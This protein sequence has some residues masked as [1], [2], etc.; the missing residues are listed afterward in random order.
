MRKIYICTSQSFTLFMSLLCPP[1]PYRSRPT[2]LLTLPKRVS[3]ML[4][5]KK[6]RDFSIVRFA[7]RFAVVK[8]FFREKVSP[9]TGNQTHQNDIVSNFPKKGGDRWW[10]NASSD[11]LFTMYRDG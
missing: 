10:P 4:R 1:I 7:A 3:K 2:L 5:N 9:P 11:L 6:R 8:L